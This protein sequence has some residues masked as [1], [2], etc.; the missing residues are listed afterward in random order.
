[1]EKE[2]MT[3]RLVRRRGLSLWWAM[4][5]AWWVSYCILR[6]SNP[7]RESARVATLMSLASIKAGRGE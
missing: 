5:Q 6:Q 7:R 3:I 2:I 4:L 1:M